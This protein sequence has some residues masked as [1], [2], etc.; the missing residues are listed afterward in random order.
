MPQKHYTGTRHDYC[1]TT[2]GYETQLPVNPR[3]SLE[4]FPGLS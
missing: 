2:H 4:Y 1:A 3:A